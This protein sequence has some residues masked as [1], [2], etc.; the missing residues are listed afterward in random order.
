MNLMISIS[1]G[2]G[3]DDRARVLAGIVAD[4]VESGAL[5]AGSVARISHGAPEEGQP[6]TAA[7]VRLPEP[8]PADPA[9]TLGKVG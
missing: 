8:P 4:L 7:E 5:P 9:L 2:A 6:W 1:G 3:Q